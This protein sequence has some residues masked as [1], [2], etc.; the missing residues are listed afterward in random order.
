MNNTLQIS[1]HAHKA[2]LS[3]EQKRYNKLLTDIKKIQRDIEKTM[4]LDLELRKAGEARVSPAEKKVFTAVKEFIVQMDKSPFTGLL[5]KKQAERYHA[6]IA[7]EAGSLLNTTFFHEDEE[8]MALYDKHSEDEMSWQ[9]QM[10]ADEA[11]ELNFTAH[12]ANQMFG[13]DLDPDDLKDPEKMMHK[14][15]QRKE[16]MM[17]EQEAYEAKRKT[18]KKSNKQL[19]AEVNKKAAET[20]VNKTTKQIYLDLVKHFH[21]DKEADEKRRAEKTEVMK[22]ITAA[23]EA[24]N[25]LKLL[26][27]QMNLLSGE[28]VFANFD[29]KQL[30]YFNDVLKTQKE[31]LEMELYMKHPDNNGNMY[32]QLFDNEPFIMEY[33]IKK[34]VKGQEKYAHTFS[35]W[36]NMIR[37]KEGFNALVKD[38]ELEEEDDFDFFGPNLL[39]EFFG[40]AGR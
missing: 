7:Q 5:K 2:L 34:H 11:E 17:A 24:N 22:E 1:Q 36:T 38:Y 16:E 19:E 40:R 6:I 13:M 12:M 9:E 18:R 21:P 30:K 15:N 33:N 28:N 31:E 14:I 8:V 3:K 25:H 32:A 20:A 29:E 37:T 26:E 23:Y 27:L 35:Q 39:A 10:E 4:K